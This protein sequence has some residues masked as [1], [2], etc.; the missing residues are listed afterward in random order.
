MS[1]SHFF[2]VGVAGAGMSALAQYLAQRGFSVTGSDRQFGQ[3]DAPVVQRQLE[4][5]GIRCVAQDGSGVDAS[6]NTVVVSTAI[7]K[8]NPDLDRALALGIPVLHRSELLARLTR[9]RRTI[10][11]SGTSGKSTVTGMVWHILHEVG[12]SPSLL[13]GAGLSV[14]EAQGKI[15]N[16]VAG[17]G[18][19]LV[20]EADESDGT[21]VRYAP[22]VGVILNIDKDHKEISELQELFQTFA[23]QTIGPLIVNG[24]HPLAEAFAKE[25]SW[26]FGPEG[27]HG[28]QWLD[29]EPV[30]TGIRFRLRR[31][32]TLLRV[33]L[34]V[35][36]RHNME[37]ATA[38]IACAVAAGVPLRKAV[39]ALRSWGGIHRRHQI[40]GTVR[41]VTLVDDF[42]HNP[43]K[44]VASI[45]A[46]QG[47]TSG[48]VLAWFQPHGF[49]PTRFLR[50]DLVKGIEAALRPGDAIWFSRIYYAGGTAVQDISAGDLVQDLCDLGVEAY[51]EPDRD[52]AARVLVAQAHSGDT[53]LLMGARD[54]GLA[55]FTRSVLRLLES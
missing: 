9:E 43:A 33:E 34:P 51:Y 27:K 7:E 40:L 44:I 53:L 39:E 17:S 26:V 54:P 42:A 15:G 11:V 22:E 2:F 18:E 8:G 13:S 37:N 10:A 47:F 31:A 45:R 16:A 25:L 23:A 24:A 52:V 20:C 19:W 32:G 46:C 4:V 48:R 30:G 35:P 21:L 12:L 28:F 49:G 50:H 55:E 3:K 14:L 1:A 38:A 36:G 29:Y 41:G 5:E 6:V